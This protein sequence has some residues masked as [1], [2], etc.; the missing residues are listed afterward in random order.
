MRDVIWSH[1]K[2]CKFDNQ[3]VEQDII[4]ITIDKM[5]KNMMP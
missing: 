1:N 2:N 3:Q 4:R 5:A